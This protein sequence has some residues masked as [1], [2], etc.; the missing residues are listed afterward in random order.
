M[1]TD[2]DFSERFRA[3][4]KVVERAHRG[5]PHDRWFVGEKDMDNFVLAYSILVKLTAELADALQEATKDADTVAS[6]SG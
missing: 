6:K 4:D 5:L 2:K 1:D 3:A